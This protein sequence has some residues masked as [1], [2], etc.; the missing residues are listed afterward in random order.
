MA[1]EWE[2]E[3]IGLLGEAR[4][5]L[6]ME[7]KERLSKDYY[8]Y[9]PVLERQLKEKI[10]DGIVI[11]KD[12]R[13]VS[14][15]LS[16]AYRH[17]I[18]VTV[19]GAGTGNYGQAVPL[20]GGI[21]MDMSQLD[22]ILEVGDGYARVQ[23][24]VRLG[25]LE[26]HLRERG[27]ELRI[28]PSTF[29]KATVGGFVCGG[30]GGIGSITWGN[31][32][33]GNVL[34]A[35]VYTM[36]EVPRRLVVQG[37]DLYPYIHNYGTTG[38]VTELTIASAPKTEWMQTV[39]HFN[40]IASAVQFGE[41]LAKEEAIPKRL[42]S[43][44][45]WPIPAYF[46]PLKK[47]L[48]PGAAAVFLEIANGTLTAVSGLAQSMGGRV[49]HIIEAEQYRKTIGLSD[50]T[51]NH[52]TLWALKMDPAIT[53]LQA[54]FAA[55]RYLEQIRLIKDEFGDEVLL[56]FEWVKNGGRLSLASLPLIRFKSEE[57]LY[58]IIRFFEANGVNIFD[59]HTWVLDSGG[60][61]EVGAMQRKKRENDPLG[62]LN[63]GKIVYEP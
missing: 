61:G 2:K 42:I 20:E 6:D 1:V 30:S 12:E 21:V 5:L 13:E 60:R 41:A 36:E 15:V 62:L 37:Q 29:M 57:R 3:M 11:P 56:H 48:E 55:D 39:I 27:Q 52:T 32:W 33:D 24:G 43:P 46:L 23:C 22:E 47:V 10:A 28:Y 53:Y 49:G 26:K 31:L 58:E 38:I 17:R 8:W 7:S 25:S 50:F 19:R 45:E 18:P 59:P 35:A 14:A 54:G 34:E 63:P 16:F 51:W 4:L 40:D 9:S 44:M